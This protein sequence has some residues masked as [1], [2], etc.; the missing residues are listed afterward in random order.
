MC[1]KSFCAV[2]KI[3]KY[4]LDEKVFYENIWEDDDRRG[5]GDKGRGRRNNT[6]KKERKTVY[7]Q[8]LW[9]LVR[10]EESAKLVCKTRFN[11]I[12]SKIKK[13]RHGV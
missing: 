2:D 11:G 8:T 7:V 13:P 12:K 10:D 9:D 6:R 4:I 5:R 3:T 1:S